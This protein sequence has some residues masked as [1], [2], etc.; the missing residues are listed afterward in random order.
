MLS[1][2]TSTWLGADRLLPLPSKMR[3]F[4]GSVTGAGA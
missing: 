4:R 1:P 3:T 2:R